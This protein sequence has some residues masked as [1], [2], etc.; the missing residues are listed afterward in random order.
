MDGSPLSKFDNKDLW[1]KEMRGKR[2]E[3]RSEHREK[4]RGDKETE[5]QGDMR[6]EKTTDHL[7]LTTPF[8]ISVSLANHT[9]IW[10]LTSSST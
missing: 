2:G 7:P 8:K 3:E 1:N 9:S 5:R 10:I 6:D 4:R